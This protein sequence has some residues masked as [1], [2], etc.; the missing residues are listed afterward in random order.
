MSIDA[1]QCCIRPRTDSEKRKA[2][3]ARES[4]RL[5]RD[6]ERQ[7]QKDEERMQGMH[8]VLLL[9]C[10]QAGKSTF[11]K[12][13][14]IINS[15]EFN[16]DEKAKFKRDIAS[17]IISAITTLVE[18]IPSENESDF[19]TDLEL[20]ESYEAVRKL[21]DTKRPHPD[22]V[23]EVANHIDKIWKCSSLQAAYANRSLFQI[24]DCA[25]YFLDKVIEVMDPNY[26]VTNDDIVHARVKTEGILEYTY[27]MPGSSEKRP[28]TLTFVSNN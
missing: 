1:V 26:V 27:S 16:E 18:N 2:E 23:H 13:M 4:A 11:I 22:Q 17:N 20:I 8:R 15:A 19:Y 10:G 14:R 28:Q 5:H 12:Q 3:K 7:L 6:I 21:L 24:V 9:G 25:K